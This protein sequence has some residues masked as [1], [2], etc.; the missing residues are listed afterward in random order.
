MEYPQAYWTRDDYYMDQETT[1]TAD[2]TAETAHKTADADGVFLDE[3]TG[4]GRSRRFW[5]IGIVLIL[6]VLA[7][8][9]YFM[10]RGGG[11]AAGEEA[12]AAEGEAGDGQIPTVTVVIPGSGNIARMISATGTLAARREMPVGVAGE[13]GQVARVLVEPGSWVRQGQVLATIDQSV[14]SQ[15]ANSAA[16]QISVA[17][18]DAELAQ[19]EL[20]RALKLVER[21]FI[22]KADID[23]KT[24]T[25]DAARARVNVARAQLNELRAR[26]RRLNITAPAAGLVL[27]RNV[28]PGQVVSAGS[29]VLFR[30]AKGGEMEL[31]A[32]L[33]EDD[34]S[35][36]STGV[37]AKVTPVGS[38]KV[39]DGQVWQIAPVINPQTRQGIARIALPYDA[40]L[41][42]GGFASAN[43]ASGS[44]VAPLLPESAVQSD[45]E[46]AY[47]Y[48]VGKD[49]KI[50]RRDVGTGVVTAD[51]IAINSGLDGS[52]RIV[53]YAAGFLNP[54]ETVKPVVKKAE[55]DAGATGAEPAN[56]NAKPATIDNT[57]AQAEPAG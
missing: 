3:E 41:R 49:N 17:Q 54:G 56:D 18:A 42:P 34:L 30:M 2:K 36:L 25:R 47:V 4:T 23:R 37:S 9:G 1:F 50:E 33:S 31:R 22:S 12:V 35:R 43:I 39:F 38:E 52:E 21:G 5:V 15:Q 28:E 26:T 44:S 13:G 24:A 55:N 40:A 8:A 32:Q 29:G 11:D 14:Q 53:L 7:A 45:D 10:T 19:S 20:D 48:I 51:G 6:A 57:E 16:A 46:G 27:E